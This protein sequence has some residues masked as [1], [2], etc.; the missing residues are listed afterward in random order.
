MNWIWR[1]LSV[2]GEAFRRLAAQ[3]M[4]SLLNVTVI[5]IA[6][7]LP[8]GFYIIVDNLER[9]SRQISG[10]PQ[11]S[12]FLT[13]DAT[14]TD[15]FALEQKLKVHAGV[16]RYQ[17]ISRGA[18]LENLKRG[19]GEVLDNL[20]GN[21]LPDAFIVIAQDGQPEVLDELRDTMRK[22]PKVA[23]VQVDS[24]WAR[25]LDLALSLGRTLAR[26]LTILLAIGL[27]AITFNTIRLQILTRHEE[28]E[29][30]R[31]I[32]ATDAYIRRPFLYFGALQ[33]VFGGLAAWVIVATSA[34]LLNRGLGQ[35]GQ[36][37]GSELRIA[38][39]SGLDAVSLLLFSGLLGLLGAW[40]SVSRH[41]WSIQPK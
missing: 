14:A 16:K 13:L 3:P 27:V 5:G 40:M 17:F 11:L 12:I 10:E 28:I 33:G 7:A 29:V 24:E 30:S 18:A 36:A 41:L 19:L 8:V 22:W 6:L 21:P 4:A 15:S 35:L 25:R 9:F 20:R 39:L 23:H 26:L 32:G 37:Y 31:L 34:W 38:S 2:L 1:N